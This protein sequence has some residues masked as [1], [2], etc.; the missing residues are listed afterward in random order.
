MPRSSTK[1][2]VTEKNLDRLARVVGRH[3][4]RHYPGLHLKV[5]VGGKVSWTWR[6]RFNGREF[7]LGLGPYPN[8]GLE[9]AVR[10]YEERRPLLR[11]GIDPKGDRKP[12]GAEQPAKRATPIF[13]EAAEIYIA[14]HAREK[15]SS[16]IR[17]WRGR[18]RRLP[19]WFQELPV[20]RI[21]PE[22]VFDALRPLWSEIPS[23]AM[24]LRGL[25]EQILERARGSKDTRPNPAA[26]TGWLKTQLGPPGKFK[27]APNGKR[28]PTGN[29]PSLPYAKVPALLPR[30]QEMPRIAARTLAFLILTATRSNEAIGML[31]N[32]FHP[33]YE[34]PVDGYIGPT[35]II[36]AERMKEKRAHRVPLSSAALT[37]LR[38][39]ERT[40]SPDSPYVFPG[41][42]PGRP[43]AS[44][45]MVYLLNCLFRSDRS[46]ELFT[47]HGFRSSFRVWCQNNGVPFEVAELSLAHVVGDQTVRAYA[48]GDLLKLRVD[49]MRRWGAFCLGEP[50]DAHRGETP[51]RLKLASGKG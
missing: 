47:V 9:G 44:N 2:P 51:A 40:R 5:V 16:T 4:V 46:L 1:E 30:L 24:E 18:L 37:I 39:Q 36:P 38:G 32:E 48:R 25:I 12:R 27:F 31:W 6:Y 35:W 42:A 22:N 3:P 17:V 33:A 29:L 41:R 45:V 15:R 19:R 28:V 7:E 43:N 10:A 49:V 20:G 23:T 21:E 26:W 8:I 50:E 13:A 14:E 34:D 11:A